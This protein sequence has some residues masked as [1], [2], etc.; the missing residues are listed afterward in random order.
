MYDVNEWNR[1]IYRNDDGSFVEGD[2]LTPDKLWTEFGIKSFP[3]FRESCSSHIPI[4]WT[5][6]VRAFLAQVRVELGDR[7]AFTQLKEQ[8]CVLVVYF[9]A[10]DTEAENRLLELK[11]ECVDRLI[12]KGIHPDNKGDSNE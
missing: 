11:R 3:K 6:D 8:W 12:T 9:E 1:I 2:Q 4:K 5:D 10:K 7:I